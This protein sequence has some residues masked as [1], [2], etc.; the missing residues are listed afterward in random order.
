MVITQNIKNWD[1]KGQ[2]P[3][4]SLEVVRRDEYRE[5]E[6]T[7]LS[8]LAIQEMKIRATFSIKL[9]EIIMAH[10]RRVLRNTGLA[11]YCLF[12]TAWWSIIR[13]KHKAV[14][15]HWP[16]N[17]PLRTIFWGTSLWNWGWRKTVNLGKAIHTNKAIDS[18]QNIME[19]TK[20]VIHIRYW[21]TV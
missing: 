7:G 16:I 17:S 10:Y 5:F 13:I 9:S 12:A 14:H 20:T 8:L 19:I 1:L 6:T 21:I 4:S 2:Y 11:A 18:T 3:K 15:C